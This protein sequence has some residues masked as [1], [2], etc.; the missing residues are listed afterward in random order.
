MKIKPSDALKL[1]RWATN[2]P[3]VRKA[4]RANGKWLKLNSM[5]KF[6]KIDTIK[7]REKCLFPELDL[8]KIAG[9]LKCR[10]CKHRKAFALNEF[11]P[12]VVQCC[13]LR[14]SKKSNS[15]YVTIRVTDTACY[16]YEKREKE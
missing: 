7:I 10:T 16:A 3:S 15:G 6:D 4:A 14:P 11:S 12:K 1:H 2:P 8:A 5:D 9:G 13:T